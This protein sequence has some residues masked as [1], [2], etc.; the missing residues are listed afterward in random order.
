MNVIYCN[1][2][3][4]DFQIFCL[5][6]VE[7]E[8][9]S[10]DGMSFEIYQTSCFCKIKVYLRLVYSYYA[11]LIKLFRKTKETFQVTFKK[12]LKKLFFY[13]KLQFLLIV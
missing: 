13:E 7:K 6:L 5:C 4:K 1:K 12:I 3:T 11:F 10:Q 9:F 8:Y 2:I